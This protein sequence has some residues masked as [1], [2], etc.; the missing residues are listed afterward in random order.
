VS[1][2]LGHAND[3]TMHPPGT[4]PVKLPGRRDSVQ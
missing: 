3:Y 4:S 1:K 2:A